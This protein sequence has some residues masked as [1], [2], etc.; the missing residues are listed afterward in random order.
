MFI[1]PARLGAVVLALS[2]V[3]WLFFYY[4][5][6]PPLSGPQTAFVVGL[7][8]VVVSGVRWVWNHIGLTR[9]KT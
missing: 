1:L 9:S 4:T 7:V 6:E 5:T 3:I 8:T 2:L